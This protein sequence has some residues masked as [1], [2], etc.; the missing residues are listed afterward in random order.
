MSDLLIL[1][2]FADNIIMCGSDDKIWVLAKSIMRMEEKADN[3][4]FL[5]LFPIMFLYP[6]LTRSFYPRIV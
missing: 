4:Q 1:N 5:D 6:S 3:H 2:E